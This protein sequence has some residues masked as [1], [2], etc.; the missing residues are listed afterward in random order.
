MDGA[1]EGG[2]TY[3]ILYDD[4]DRED[5]VTIDLIKT[6][7]A[8]VPLSPAPT[9]TINNTTTVNAVNDGVTM[10]DQP[11]PTSSPSSVPAPVVPLAVPN[12]EESVYG[13]FVIAWLDGRLCTGN[14]S[15]N[16][17]ISYQPKH[18]PSH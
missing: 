7:N 9:A 3:D 5:K 2:Y 6:L 16:H 14:I 12:R 15:F 4:G 10:S 17:I 13:S 18:F 11:K 8:I 1:K